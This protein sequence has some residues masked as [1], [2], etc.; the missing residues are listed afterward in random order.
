MKTRLLLLFLCLQPMFLAAQTSET[1]SLVSAADGLYAKE[2]FEG[3]CK[4]YQQAL[5]HGESSNLCYDIGNCYYRLDDIAKAVLWYERAYILNPGDEDIRFNLDMARSKTI[6]KVVPRHEFFFVTWYK[7]MVNWMSV[8][9]WAWVCLVLFVLSL[10]AISLY[11]YG[12]QIWLRKLGFTLFVVLLLM[13]VLGN[14]CAWSQRSRLQNRTGAI[15]MSPSA[16]VKST[17]SK[18]GSDL[19]VLHEGTR[20]DI[21]D[22]TLNDWWEVTLA[23]GKQGWIQ[24]KQIEVI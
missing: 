14:V 24:R 18:S 3:S 12:K 1:D 5:E 2:N 16:V 19:F 9:A 22:A 17:P 23:D 20:V 6:D 13:T 4:T 11:I 8:D 10:L 21:K 7:T 15:V